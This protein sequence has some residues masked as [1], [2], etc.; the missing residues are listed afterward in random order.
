MTLVRKGTSLLLF[1]S[2]LLSAAGCSGAVND[3]NSAKPS[4][5]V[6]SPV[7]TIPVAA[8][9]S[10]AKPA[11]PLPL[12]VNPP[13]ISSFKSSANKSTGT[14]TA[15]R[16]A[17]PLTGWAGGDGW[18][19]GTTDGGKHWN[20]QLQHPYLVQQIFALNAK[21]AWTTL[22]I[23]DKRGLKLI[24]T[25][26]GGKHWKDAGTVPNYSFFHF[27]SDT[28]A[29]SGNAKTTDGGKTWT[30]LQVPAA[31]VGDAY[32]HD[33]NNGWAVTAGNGKFV[34]QKTTD[35]GKSWRAVFTRKT[36]VIPG[37]A[38]IRST[39]AR[40]AWVEL[41]GDSGMT[42]TSYSLFHTADGG[43][44]WQPVLAD[45][46]AGSGP[47][48]GFSMDEKKVPRNTG[49]S[50]GMLYVV[51]PSIAFMGGQC[52]AC[53]NPNTIGKTT[54]GG[55]SWINLKPLYPGYGP[56]QIAAA[57]ANHVWWINTDHEQPSRMYV[58][59]DGGQHWTLV[60]TFD[61]PK[62]K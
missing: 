11:A 29:Y 27:V 37:T 34:I 57:D 50:P 21:K 9:G 54:N 32:F 46:G 1:T 43:K 15:V 16:L 4:E 51:N 6:A 17:D 55:K 45:S 49:N 25:L 33:R 12:P 36:Q 60:H 30:K 44:S 5:T 56:Q 35:G 19:A 18:L 40:D 53:D 31:I 28:E 22:D 42:Q 59:S 48:P 23:G 3:A 39:G 2:L 20:V 58:T 62:S 24:Q 13:S 52:E 10:S 14:V 61:K 38:M 26:D 7:T 8:E 41:I 47:A